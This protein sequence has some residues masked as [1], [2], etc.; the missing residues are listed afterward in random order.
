MPLVA[1]QHPR[2]ILKLQALSGFTVNIMS[3]QIFVKQES[4][5][6]WIGVPSLFTAQGV[7]RLSM[8][9]LAQTAS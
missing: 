7:L 8:P 2:N 1:L 9:A 5:N 6:A 4:K 3:L